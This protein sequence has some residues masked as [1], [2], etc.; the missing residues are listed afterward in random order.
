M[1]VYLICYAASYLFA[2]AGYYWLSGLVL[3]LAAV[4]LYWYDYKSTDFMG[5][6]GEKL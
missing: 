2:R 5:D 1:G 6:I 3:I 4:W